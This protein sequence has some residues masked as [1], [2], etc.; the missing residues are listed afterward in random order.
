M[1]NGLLSNNL[2]GE[3]KRVKDTLK[4]DGLKYSIDN[5]VENAYHVDIDGVE[6]YFDGMKVAFKASTSNSNAATFEIN[7]LGQIPIRKSGTLELDPE[8]VKQGQISILMYDSA[9]GAF[10]IISGSGLKVDSNQY[11]SA[12]T[13]PIATVTNFQAANFSNQPE[14]RLNWI[15]PPDLT[16][17]DTASNV[18]TLA[19]LDRVVIRAATTNHPIDEKDGRLVF[20]GLA[21]TFDDIGLAYDEKQYYS[22]FAIT[23]EG[24]VSEVAQTTG[25]PKDFTMDLSYNVSD[26]SINGATETG[27]K[28]VITLTNPT[29]SDYAGTYI[30]YSTTTYPSNLADGQ[31]GYDGTGETIEVTG[32]T[33]DQIYYF[34]IWAYN[35]QQQYYFTIW[36]YDDQPQYSATPIEVQTEVMLGDDPTGSPGPVILQAGDTTAG[37]FG[38]VT[39]AEMGI[40]GDTLASDLGITQGTSQFATVDWLKYMYKGHV[41]FR[42][43]KPFRHSISWDYLYS[44][45]AVYATGSTISAGEQWMIDNDDQRTRVPQDAQVTKNGVTYKVGLMNVAGE[46]P[47][48]SYDDSDHGVRG[49]EYNAIILPLHANA[50]SSFAYPEYADAPTPDWRHATPDGNGFTDEDLHTNS[51]YGDGTYLWGQE[52]IDTSAGTRTNR[53]SNGASYVYS[54]LSSGTNSDYGWL[55]RLEVVE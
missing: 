49:S 54:Y 10:Q 13:P 53:G 33:D 20:E 52:T 23:K 28:A 48:N 1:S 38:V 3:N 6:E 34:T 41:R 2:V 51:S 37:Y 24:I 55:P 11:I 39:S 9:E 22:I 12:I 35:D 16:I 18:I 29:E 47:T 7:S 42:P 26:V 43:L 14:L 40:D 21:E 32:L 8:D 45:G 46:D 4:E 19:E 44:A 25:T 27:G 30:R 17:T 15:N 50:P 31:L 36:A 5:G